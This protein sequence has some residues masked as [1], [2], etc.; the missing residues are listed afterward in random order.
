MSTNIHRLTIMKTRAIVVPKE[1]SGKSVVDVVASLA[2]KSRARAATLVQQ[3]KV[4]VGG[5]V[6]RKADRPLRTGQRVTLDFADEPRFDGRPGQKQV[7]RD[8]PVEAKAIVVVYQDSDIIVVD[9]P[10]GLTTVRHADEAA[11]AGRGQRYLPATLV[12]VLPG[13]VKGPT[14]GRFRIRAVHRLDRD[15][16]GLIVLARTVEAESHLG[17]QFRAHT[18]ERGYLALVRG[19]AVEKRIESDLVRDRGDGRRGTGEG[20]DSQH[21]VTHVRVVETFPDLSLVECRLET[22][23]THQVR[24][25]LGEQGIPLCGERIYDRPLHG[26][27]APDPSGAKR[28]MLHAAS[29]E[30]THPRSGRRMKWA[31]EPPADF[32]EILRRV[33]GNKTE[34]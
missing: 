26:K 6:C 2:R 15:T 25:H 33:R 28:P 12:D 10:V 8:V 4:R 16:S 34:A 27:P 29:L 22:G 3:G 18:I 1:D 24:I 23:R 9:K 21:A 17:K 5:Q 30:I 19:V 11:E 7:V 31:V 32:A 20:K 13:R 14:S